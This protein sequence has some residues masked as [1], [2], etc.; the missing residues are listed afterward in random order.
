MVGHEEA[1][2][3][4]ASGDVLEGV[5]G[6]LRSHLEDLGRV[7]G[8]PRESLGVLFKKDEEEST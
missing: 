2:L 8:C 3:G 7:L 1:N 6:A 4:E 5:S